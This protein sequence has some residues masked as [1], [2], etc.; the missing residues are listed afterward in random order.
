MPPPPVAAP[1]PL[2]PR[3]AAPAR[4]RP[5]ALRAAAFWRWGWPEWVA[6]TPILIPALMFIPGATS[7]RLLTRI[8]TFVP[9]L[10]AWFFVARSARGA[11]P[12]TFAAAPVMAGCLAWLFLSILHPTTN[13]PTSG[14]AQAMLYLAV[15]CPVF[16]APRAIDAP[17]QLTR[18]M[19]LLLLGNGLSS[20]LGVAQFYRP[21]RFNPPVMALLDGNSEVMEQALSYETADGRRVFRPCGL[22]DSPGNAAVAGLASGV[23]GLAWAIR[24]GRWWARLGAAALA[25]AGL[26][27]IY[28]TQVRTSLIL[29]G[30]AVA[31]LATILALRRDLGK[32]AALGIVAAALTAG[33][34]ARVARDGGAAVVERFQSLFQEDASTTY[35]N[36][37][38]MFVEH[39][40]NQL[41]W[42]YPLGAGMGRW[43][44]MYG[45]FG[46]KALGREGGMLWAELQLVGWVFDG[47]LI[48]LVGYG[49]GLALALADT[50]RVALTSRDRELAFWAAVAAALNVAVAAQAFGSLPF[51]SA[52]G[53]QFWL[54]AGLVH[55]ADRLARAGR[56]AAATT[57][58]TAARRP[59]P[60][61]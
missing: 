14:F 19:A 54:L 57:T 6:L 28:F 12:N 52:P 59:A 43:G 40:Y 1:P 8:G 44:R 36:T 47:G 2:R 41:I 49:L 30:I 21:E 38:G 39:V 61:R 10:L 46:N 48:L 33:V 31:T 50:V 45:Y 23:L 35:Y 20:L 4:P 27:A 32:L 18:V 60:A 16:W 7:V 22:S 11:R 37:R 5:P 42:N 55:G 15:F 17:R 56:P 3:P 24:P 34:G 26:A 25:G 13:S 51:V 9:P 58:A 53:V 29:L